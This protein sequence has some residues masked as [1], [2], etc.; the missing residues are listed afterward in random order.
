MLKGSN[1][2]PVEARAS[3]RK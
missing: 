2:P 3:C 1:T